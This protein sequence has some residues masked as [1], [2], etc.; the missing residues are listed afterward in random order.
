MQTS[1]KGA[2]V[3]VIRITIVRRALSFLL[4]IDHPLGR[5]FSLSLSTLRIQDGGPD[6]SQRGTE[7]SL[8]I[9]RPVLQARLFYEARRVASTFFTRG[10]CLIFR[11]PVSLNA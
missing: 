5:N 2:R 1:H 10:R 7:R 6:I 8:D 3:S 11:S 9:N 4:P